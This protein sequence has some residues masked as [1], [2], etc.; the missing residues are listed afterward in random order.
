MS[1]I[2]MLCPDKA[3]DRD[4]C[5]KMAIVHDMAEALVGDITP[6]DGV[7]KGKN[8]SG[9]VR[10]RGPCTPVPK[11]ACSGNYI[12]WVRHVSRMLISS[13]MVTEIKHS[14]ELETMNY[15]KDLLSP[16]NSRV[17]E[18]ISSLW[19]EYEDGET[20]EA[21]FVKDGEFFVLRL[22]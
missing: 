2:A 5:I 7:S 1:V 10:L 4:R 13:S 16:L 12:F 18:E 22:V 21:I 20:P 17:A 8:G 11:L 14:R 3:L 6:T 19:A 15:I 9:L